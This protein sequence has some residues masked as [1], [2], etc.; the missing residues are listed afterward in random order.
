MVRHVHICSVGYEPGAILPVFGSD[1]PV[2]KV[3]LLWNE[4][5]STGSNEDN[6]EKIRKSKEEIESKVKGLGKECQCEII[7]PFDYY[8]IVETVIRVARAEKEKSKDVKL[9]S[10]FTSGTSIV[11]GAMCTSS[12][13]IGAELYYVM[14]PKYLADNPR[15]EGQI[16]RIPTPKIPDIER[17][18][19]RSQEIL[20]YISKHDDYISISSLEE[21]GS[22][23]RVNYHIKCLIDAE[24]I[25]RKHDKGRTQVRI[26]PLGKMVSEWIY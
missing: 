18:G 9:Y 24:L 7:N 23:Q 1:M 6:V 20:K 19:I 8:S 14:D 11:R 13:F 25:E 21:F 22:K 16:L 2:D 17:M 4:K 26:K 10:N 15:A 5:S 3:Y 12:Y